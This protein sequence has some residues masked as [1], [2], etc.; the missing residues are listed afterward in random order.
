MKKIKVL[1]N[2]AW[3][4]FIQYLHTAPTV[5]KLLTFQLSNVRELET[6]KYTFGQG[7]LQL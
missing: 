5:V 3:K 2:F 6:I 1:G 7:S 4:Q